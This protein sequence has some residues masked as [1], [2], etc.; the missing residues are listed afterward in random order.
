MQYRI[1]EENHLRCAV[2]TQSTVTDIQAKKVSDDWDYYA[3]RKSVRRKFTD[4]YVFYYLYTTYL[5]LNH[6][7]ICMKF[8]YSRNIWITIMSIVSTT[9]IS[10]L[11]LSSYRRYLY[12]WKQ[13]YKKISFKKPSLMDFSYST[14][15]QHRTWTVP[16]ETIGE[17]IIVFIMNVC[18]YVWCIMYICMYVLKFSYLYVLHSEYTCYV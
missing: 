13:F 16:F 17:T 9:L 6:N 11:F 18:M 2:I 8:I 10:Y 1:V 3:L 15:S 4:D 5:L 14:S 12:L 7:C